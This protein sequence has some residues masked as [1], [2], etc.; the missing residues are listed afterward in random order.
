MNTSSGNLLLEYSQDH[1]KYLN[2]KTP[3]QTRAIKPTENVHSGTQAPSTNPMAIKVIGADEKY[4]RF[5]ASDKA[6]WLWLSIS[7]SSRT[8]TSLDGNPH[9]EQTGSWEPIR[10]VIRTT[11]YFKSWNYVVRKALPTT[12]NK[13][14]NISTCRRTS[15]TESPQV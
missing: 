12:S 8:P 3:R 6:A 11:N 7:A 2:Q 4:N 14:S 1:R 5:S 15:A 9:F 10:F 13:N